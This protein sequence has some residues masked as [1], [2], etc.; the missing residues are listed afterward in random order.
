MSKGSGKEL[1]LTKAVQKRFQKRLEF[2]SDAIE[3]LD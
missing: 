1:K 2:L 3:E